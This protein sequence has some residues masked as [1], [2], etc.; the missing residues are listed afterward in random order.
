MV[1][2]VLGHD[3]VTKWLIKQ[4]A[5]PNLSDGGEM[6]SFHYSIWGM[7]RKR[8]RERGR[9]GGREKEENKKLK[10]MYM[11]YVILVILQLQNILVHTVY[12]YV[13]NHAIIYYLKY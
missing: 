11:L 8:G 1:S 13:C 12:M 6:N 5:D 3:E 7:V 4:A 9:E 2:C 10:C